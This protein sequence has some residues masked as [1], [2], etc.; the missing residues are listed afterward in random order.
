MS[1]FTILAIDPGLSGALA[2]YSSRSR[3]R[4]GAGIRHAARGGRDRRA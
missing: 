1:V 2:F 3:R 4:H